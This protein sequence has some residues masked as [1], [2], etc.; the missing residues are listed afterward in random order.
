MVK[1][2][3]STKSGINLLDGFWEKGLYRRMTDRRMDDGHPCDDS[4]AAAQTELKFLFTCT[5]EIFN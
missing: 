2:Y 3:L 1:R 4:S 5:S